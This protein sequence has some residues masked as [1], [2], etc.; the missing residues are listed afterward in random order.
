MKLTKQIAVL[1]EEIIFMKE[2][3]DK[4]QKIHKEYV[5]MILKYSNNR[6]ERIKRITGTIAV[7]KKTALKTTFPKETSYLIL[8]CFSSGLNNP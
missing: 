8:F 6:K 5:Q 2:N 7:S 3:K 4:F 1:D